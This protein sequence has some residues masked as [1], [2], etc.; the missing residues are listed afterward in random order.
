MDVLQIVRYGVL[1]CRGNE[2]TLHERV[3]CTTLTLQKMKQMVILTLLTLSQLQ[4]NDTIS[5][6]HSVFISP[7]LLRL[8]ACVECVGSVQSNVCCDGLFAV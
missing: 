2:I 3:A 7:I 1:Q 6:P 8:S 5:L 4:L